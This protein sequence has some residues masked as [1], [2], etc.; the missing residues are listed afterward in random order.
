MRN[1]A[2]LSHADYDYICDILRRGNAYELEELALLVDSFPHGDDGWHHWITVA[3]QLGAV[4]AVAWMI[5]AGVDLAI[6]ES[7]GYTVL[8]SALE[9]DPPRRYELLRLLIAGHAPL[10]LQG[11]NDWTP[12][13]MAAAR[14]DIRALEL[15]MRAGADPSIRT[16]IDD[17]TTPLEEARILGRWQSVRFLEQYS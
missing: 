16:R 12:L 14:E 10:N 8:I 1:N 5:S 7:D 6:H 9:H 2:L 3:I 15:L 13:H 4:A 11:I 17:Y